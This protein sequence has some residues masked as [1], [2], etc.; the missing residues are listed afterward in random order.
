MS[1]FNRRDRKNKILFL[2]SI[3][4][5]FIFLISFISAQD[6]TSNVDDVLSYKGLEVEAYKDVNTKLDGTWDW[7]IE[8]KSFW[9]S[10]DVSK[11]PLTE[12]YFKTNELKTSVECIDYPFA[13][14]CSWEEIDFSPLINK[15]ENTIT[16]TT[17]EEV[18]DKEGNILYYLYGF[19]G[20]IMNLDPTFIQIT[21]TVG[22]LYMGNATYGSI[23]GASNQFIGNLSDPYN[24]TEGSFRSFVFY[25]STSQYWNATLEVA[26]SNGSA[27]VY[28]LCNAD[29]N[30]VSY[31]PLDNSQGDV[32]VYADAKG[33]NDGTPTGT[34]NAT[35]LSSGAMYFD[36]T[37]DYIEVSDNEDLRLQDDFTISYW[38][39]T[40]TLGSSGQHIDK[41]NTASPYQGWLSRKT[42]ADV[43]IFSVNG[44]YPL[45]STT[46]ID[47]NTWYH[48]TFTRNSSNLILYINGV[49]DTVVGSVYPVSWNGNMKMG[50]RHDNAL[51]FNGSLD[52][53]LIFNESLTTSEIEALYKAGLSQHAIANITLETRTADN[54]NISDP[55]LVSFWSLNGN[56]NDELGINN[57]TVSGAVYGEDYGVVGGGYSFDGGDYINITDSSS[58]IVGA[59]QLTTSVWVNR[60]TSVNYGGIFESRSANDNDFL[61]IYDNN[62]AVAR[63]PSCLLRVNGQYSV[64]VSNQ[65]TPD[66]EWHNIVCTWD[67]S[68]G[69]MVMYINGVLDTSAY[70]S[71]SDAK[72]SILLT[73]NFYIG[74]DPTHIGTRDYKGRIDEVRM[75]NRSLSVSEI[76]NL[77][78]LGTTH[79]E[80][81]SSWGKDSLANTT[82]AQFKFN[83]W[84]DDTD[85]SAYLLGYNVTEGIG[86]PGV[87]VVTPS[88]VGSIYPNTYSINTTGMSIY[89]NIYKVPYVQLN[90]SL[91]FK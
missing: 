14:Q 46:T 80:D 30:C 79:I 28:D 20:T 58:M 29:A 65:V 21:K 52:E 33:S 1:K 51:D 2:F 16:S 8:N 91:I 84:S 27:E 7:V 73:N 85:V 47:A 60:K 64:W 89:P 15:K 5:F 77:Y 23:H 76:Q 4:L 50:V 43:M 81:W 54:Y 35:G 40:K 67:S 13:T 11:T 59:T 90:E 31:Y 61:L 53:V 17:L 3:P 24:S 78:E 71:S 9:P 41:M 66:N 62:G 42:N 70:S 36:G 34:N 68:T 26:D 56:A 55:S 87:P 12:F 38:F 25:N 18:T 32:N 83:F 86:V 44:T 57:G 48:I 69:N 10:K 88:N 22:D 45:T 72:S 75:Y 74:I 49:K 39:N 37:N 19:F 6:L 63:H 82:F